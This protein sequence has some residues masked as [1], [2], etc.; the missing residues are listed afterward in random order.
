MKELTC[1]IDDHMADISV[2]I[3]QDA[4]KGLL[5]FN[6]KQ[7]WDPGAHYTIYHIKCLDTRDEVC[8]FEL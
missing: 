4:C 6:I 3:L 8:R 2:F 1:T 5:V 7:I